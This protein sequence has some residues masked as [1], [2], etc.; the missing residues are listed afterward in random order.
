MKCLDDCHTYDLDMFLGIN[1]RGHYQLHFYEMQLDGTKIDG[2][3]NEEVLY[4]LIH[5]LK[6]LNDEWQGGKF[7][8]RENSLAITK[9][10]EALMW[11][12]HRTADRKK[13]KI[14]GTHNP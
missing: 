12:D 5:R 13:R 8:C 1:P 11:L 7:K 10:E 6:F 14:E 3:T 2:V 4:V 9:L